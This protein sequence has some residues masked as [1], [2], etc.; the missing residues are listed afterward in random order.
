MFERLRTNMVAMMYKLTD[1]DVEADP[2][3]GALARG[4]RP[5]VLYL[6]WLLVAA[7]ERAPGTGWKPDR[8]LTPR[9]LQSG[10]G[11]IGLRG[12]GWHG[13]GLRVARHS[14]EFVVLDL[15]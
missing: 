11:G 2:L 7:C 10:R 13:P 12:R 9:E 5:D 1:F 8:G 14:S 4:S 6:L 3:D 15:L